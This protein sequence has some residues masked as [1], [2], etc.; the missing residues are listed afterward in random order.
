VWKAKRLISS[1]VRYAHRK[2]KKVKFFQLFVASE[3]EAMLTSATPLDKKTQQ[4][5]SPGAR[6]FATI[7]TTCTAHNARAQQTYF[8]PSTNHHTVQ[9]P[10]DALD[11]HLG[12][13][14]LE[15]NPTYLTWY[16]VTPPLAVRCATTF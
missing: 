12:V 9:S 2:S 13:F 7:K 14:C 5:P 15:S 1:S 8:Q 3:K 11:R 10:L 16:S 6:A 4:E